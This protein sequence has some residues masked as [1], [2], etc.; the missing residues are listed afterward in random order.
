MQET[1]ATLNCSVHKVSYWL[2]KHGIKTRSRSEAN[3]LIYNKHSK[4]FE[5]IKPNTPYLQELYGLGIGLFWGE[6]D[7]ASKKFRKTW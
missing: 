3:Y 6:G 1:A 4:P 2:S 7:K 5:F